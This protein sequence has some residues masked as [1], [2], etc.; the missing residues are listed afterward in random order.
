M[1]TSSFEHI[2]IEVTNVCNFACEFCPD[3]ILKRPR[4]HIDLE[5][6]R[7]ILDEVATFE[8]RPTVLFHVMG[9][10]LLYPHIFDALEMA[11]E[12]DLNLELI[13]NGSTFHLIPKHI[14]KLI[15][16]NVPK[17]TISLQ[18]PDEETFTIRGEMKNLSADDYFQGIINF[19]REN[20]RSDSK[21]IVQVKFMDSTPTFFSVPYKTL[22]VI[23]GRDELR[24]HLSDWKKKFLQGTIPD[25]DL[26]ELLKKK[27]GKLLLGVPQFF[28]IHPKI[29]LY[30]F[31]LENW[32]NLDEDEFYPA[33]I[34]YCDGAV[35]QM[36]ILQD[37]K[38]TPCCTDYEG[39]IPLGNVNENSLVEILEND[40]TRTL[41][42]CFDRMR[43]D[44]PL[45]QQCLGAN[46]RGKSLVRQ[47]GAIAYYKLM[48]PI[49]RKKQR[50][51]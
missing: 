34:G 43:V 22:R 41:R 5:L 33:K 14:Q 36:G 2:H 44:D 17:V 49:F 15:A 38:V 4:G 28:K 51:D 35:G 8:G 3:M 32:G 48:K 12:C 29:V 9:E 30:S 6:L 16:A 1:P 50:V 27:F 24:H 23:K 42:E 46:T 11:V 7:K 40:A 25:S 19:T 10:P 45:C 18:T 20:M 39:L 21:T 26:E 47:V 31:P 13:T 37:G